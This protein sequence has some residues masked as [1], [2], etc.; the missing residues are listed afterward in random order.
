LNR[1]VLTAIAKLS[2]KR[3]RFHAE[4]NHQA[5]E[6]AHN[7]ILQVVLLVDYLNASVLN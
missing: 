7:Q 3:D 4:G 6:D 5:A 1:T 2:H